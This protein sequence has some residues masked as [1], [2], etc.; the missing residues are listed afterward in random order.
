[1]IF[2]TMRFN[3]IA[4]AVIAACA[5]SAT[6]VAQSDATSVPAPVDQPYAG[7]L[8]VNVDL[9][10]AG[11]RIFRSHETIPVKSGAV[12]LF[13]PQWIPGE[14]APSGPVQNVSGL[15]IRANGKQLPWRRDLR[16]MYA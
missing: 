10:D 5:L 12:T 8:T 16:D 2:R 1:M 11:K 4:A 6:A 3:L 15:I 7:T 14:H 13:Y 9:S